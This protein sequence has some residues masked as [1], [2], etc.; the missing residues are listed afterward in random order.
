M[1]GRPALSTRARVAAVLIAAFVL[2]AAGVAYRIVSRRGQLEGAARLTLSRDFPA[3]DI[4]E[5]DHYTTGLTASQFPWGGYRFTMSSRL[6][7]HLLIVGDLLYEDAGQPQDDVFRSSVLHRLTPVQS[8]ALARAWYS[9]VATQPI[10]LG[11][12]FDSGSTASASFEAQAYSLKSTPDPAKVAA[13]LR[14]LSG[15]TYGFA[16]FDG[17]VYWFRLDAASGDWTSLGSTADV[18]VRLGR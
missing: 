10:A 1:S 16:T 18:L 17:H 13:A 11:G 5:L 2:I 12:D 14:A 3:F 4:T 15:E 6:A 9:V 7:P 8:S